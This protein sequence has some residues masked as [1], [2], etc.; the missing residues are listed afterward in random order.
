[1]KNPTLRTQGT[2][3]NK[4]QMLTE[5]INV[6]N[7]VKDN[8]LREEQMNYN[9]N[10]FENYQ[11]RRQATVLNKYKQYREEWENFEERTK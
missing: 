5:V 6:Q 9:M 3:I 10:E 4:Q 1:M 8:I 2:F 11:S 7:K